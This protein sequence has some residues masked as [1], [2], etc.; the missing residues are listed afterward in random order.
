MV[1]QNPGFPQYI[2]DAYTGVDLH[3]GLS[4]TSFDVQLYVRNLL[5]ERGQVSAYT[6]EGNP[7]PAMQQPRTTG[8]TLTMRF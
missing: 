6:W 2:M 3:A 1:Y 7:R 5:D 4:F 8:L